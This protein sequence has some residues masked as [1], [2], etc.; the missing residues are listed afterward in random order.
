MKEFGLINV[1]VIKPIQFM[2]KKNQISYNRNSFFSSA[3]FNKE[4]KEY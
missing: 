4:F 2:T 3:F 1:K